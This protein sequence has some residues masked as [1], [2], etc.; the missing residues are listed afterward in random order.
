MTKALIVAAAL[1]VATLGS[2]SAA[3]VVGVIQD[4]DPATRQ[5]KLEDGTIILASA[6][7]A[8][9]TLRPGQ[10]VI[11]TFE[12]NAAGEKVATQIQLTQ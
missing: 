10:E 11:V 8:I 7:L 12:E 2:V 3:E 4:V 5:V 9:E 1:F 6:S